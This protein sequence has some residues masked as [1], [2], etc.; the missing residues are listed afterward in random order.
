MKGQLNNNENSYRSILKGTSIFG[1]VQLFQIFINLLR[2]KFVA[3]FLGPQG[4]GIASLFTSSSNTIS[5]FASLGLNLAF[6]KEAAAHKDDPHGLATVMKVVTVLLY[7]TAIGGA[8][9]CAILSPWLSIWSF[10]SADYGWQYILLSVCV[11]FTVAGYGKIAV[12]QGLRKIKIISISSLIGA[13]TGLLAG[14]PLYY[15]YGTLGIVPSMIVL[16]L[17][18][19][20]CYSFGIKRALPQ[21]KVRF[22]WQSHKPLVKKMIS[23]GMIMLASSLINTLCT[24]VLNI[25]IRSFGDMEDVGLFN[26][27]NGITIQYAGVV[28]AAM[29]MDY[30]PRLSAASKDHGLMESIINKQQ[31]IVAL[32]ATPLSILLIATA[33]I[34]IRLLLTPEFMPSM[35]LMKWLGASI[36]LKAIAYPLGYVTLAK[37]NQKLFF[38][39]EAIICN[40]LYIG[41]SLIFYYFYGLIGLGYAAVIEQA[42]CVILYLA[43]NYRAYSFKPGRTAS[44][45]TILA[46]VFCTAAFCASLAPIEALSYYLMATVFLICALRSFLMLRNLSLK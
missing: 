30:F 7:A 1:G 44:T 20:I 43:V 6:I 31:E 24:Y 23:I 29:A 41:L 32:I 12:L 16:S 35:T 40:V 26:A 3:L 38:W 25:F 13:A 34:V 36:L 28:F 22:V 19:F 37:D 4:M 17:T 18:T 21:K 45:E 15:F 9:I 27:A 14:V 42:F 39:L 8:I 33:P 5:N 46:I 11:F 10:G 2:G